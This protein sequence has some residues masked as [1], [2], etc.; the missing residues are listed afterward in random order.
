[1]TRLLPFPW[2]SAA[3]LLLWLLLNQTLSIKH[4]LFGGMLA[5]VGG[6]IMTVLALPRV[7]IGRPLAIIRLVAAVLADILRSNIA[8]A[9]IILG[10][11]E[12]KRRAG[13]VEIPLELRNPY[14]LAALACIITAT[15]GTLWVGFDEKSGLLTMHILDLI[16]DQAWIRTIKSRYEQPLLEIFT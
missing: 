5:L 12:H 11:A 16:D 3:L 13:F 10:L 2:M 4:I 1:M 7:R 14:A 9:R 6:W 8:V 15:P